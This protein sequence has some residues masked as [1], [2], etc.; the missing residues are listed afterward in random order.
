MTDSAIHHQKLR[1]HWRF[2][3]TGVSFSFLIVGK[4]MTQSK[5]T[6]K[7]PN[8][9]KSLSSLEKLVEE[10]EKGELSLEEALK[11]YEKGISLARECQTALKNAEQRV[12]T[13]MEENTQLVERAADDDDDTFEEDWLS[14]SS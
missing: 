2:V 4:I 9:E 13:L 6:S 3:Q 14:R 7:S 10:L 11:N 8:F 12:H 5:R 1:F